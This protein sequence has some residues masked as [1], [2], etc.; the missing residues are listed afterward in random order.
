[1]SQK[2]SKTNVKAYFA[3]ACEKAGAIIPLTQS[4]LD[5]WCGKLTV[6]QVKRHFKRKRDLINAIMQ[7][8]YLREKIE[9]L[10]KLSAKK[11]SHEGIVKMAIELSIKHKRKLTIEEVSKLNGGSPSTATI[12][13]CVGNTNTLWLEAE[14]LS[15]EFAN[16]SDERPLLMPFEWA[17]FWK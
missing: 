17:K 9:G 12:R 4:A 5:K 13:K 7:D 15:N 2:M 8:E 3:F 11:F 16:L 14:K 1:M 6:N 10:E